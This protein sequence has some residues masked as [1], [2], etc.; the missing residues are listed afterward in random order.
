MIHGGI[1]G[2]SRLVVFMRASNNNRSVTVMEL[3]QSAISF[4]GTPSRVRCDHGGENNAVCL[5]MELFRGRGGGSAM[6][7]RSTHN[8]RI[9][10]LWGDVWR[11]LANVYHSLFTLLEEDG[12]I[13]VTNVKTHVG[14]ALCV[15]AKD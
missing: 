5:F 11:G 12:T 14:S 1:D 7:G 2:F 8:Q 4:Y 10:R 6:R 13:D 9:E 15:P 3:F